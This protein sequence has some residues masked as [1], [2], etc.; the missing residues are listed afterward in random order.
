VDRISAGVLE[1]SMGARNRVGLGLSY[2]PARLH[3][4]ESIPGLFKNLKI[5]FVYEQA[6]LGIPTFNC[7][8]VNWAT[9]HG[10]SKCVVDRILNTLL[11][12][13]GFPEINLSA[14]PSD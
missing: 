4:L 9:Q 6:Q 12:I 5:P 10:L 8:P 13:S 11:S 3:S 14:S 7:H 2:R 1:Q